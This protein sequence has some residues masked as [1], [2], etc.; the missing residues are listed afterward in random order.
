MP[1]EFVELGDRVGVAVVVDAAEAHAKRIGGP[2]LGE[3]FAAPG[4]DALQ[5][6]GQHPL[7]DH[8]GGK[9]GVERLDRSFGHVDAQALDDAV[10]PAVGLGDPRLADL[11]P[12]A[13]RLE[14]RPVEHHVALFRVELGRRQ[15]VDELPRE[16]VDELDVGIADDEPLGHADGDADLQRQPDPRPTPE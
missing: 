12:V 11:D 10:R 16:D 2:K 15:V 9:R 1:D 8:F 14:R 6:R 5:H 3:E 13:E 4:A 7:L